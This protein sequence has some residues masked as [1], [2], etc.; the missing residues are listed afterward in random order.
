MKNEM[1]TQLIL[2]AIITCGGVAA[3]IGLAKLGEPQSVWLWCDM[4]GLCAR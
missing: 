3:S 4:I 1:I 2:A